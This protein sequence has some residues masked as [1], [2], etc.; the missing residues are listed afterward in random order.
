MRDHLLAIDKIFGADLPS[1]VP[2]RALLTEKFVDLAR[3]P[4]VA[5]AT[6]IRF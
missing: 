6:L 2:F 4:A 5:S 1:N 3:N